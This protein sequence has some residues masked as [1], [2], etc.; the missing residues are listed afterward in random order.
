VL[1]VLL[2]ASTA[3]LANPGQ[4]PPDHAAGTPAAVQAANAPDIVLFNGRISTVDSDGSEVEAIAIRDGRILATGRSGPIRALAHPHHTEL[5]DLDGRRVLPGLIDGHLHGMRNNYHCYPQTVRL[6][7][8]TSRDE[9]LAAYQAKADELASG[10]WIWTT[11]GGWNLQQLD[12]P[13]DFSF[14]EL[15]TAAP[16]NP[17]WVTGSGVAGPRVNQAAF[18]LLGLDETSDGVV[19]D[20]DGEPTGQITGP[21]SQA[22]DEAILEQLDDRTIEEWAECMAAFVQDANAHGLTAW[23]DAGGNQAP[24]GGPGE[25]SQGL[26]VHEPTMYL[27]REGGLNARIAFHQMHDYAGFEQVLSDTRNSLGFLGDDM[28]RYLGPGED[29]M[30]GDEDYHDFTRYAAEKRLSVE[31][32]VGAPVDTILDGFEAANE[33]HPIS[34]LHWTIAHPPQD[35]VHPTDE[36]LARAAALDIGFTLTISSVRNGGEGSRFRTTAESDARMCLATDAMNVAPWAPFQ[37]LWYVTTGDTLLPGVSSVP[38]E[39]QLTR[40]QAL[41]HM[42]VECAWNL[43]LEGEVGSLEVGKYADLIVLTDDYFEV[44]DDE[45]KD[46]RSVLTIVD[47]DVVWADGEYTGLAP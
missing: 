5:V 26:R 17:V 24:W 16:D 4:G 32:H 6:D 22:A 36:Q 11:F 3:V 29:T 31:T 18:D 42:T 40:E 15:S 14:D 45:V 27:H 23:K 43:D 44:A 13:E 33:V 10:L 34:E 7:L 47:G 30:G 19:L 38:E 21:A 2:A 41:R 37:L 1:A 8:I 12:V 39:Q 25:I 46:I 28:F 20:D 9:A 35:G